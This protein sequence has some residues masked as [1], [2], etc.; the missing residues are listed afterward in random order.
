MSEELIKLFR[1]QL[2]KKQY[3]ELES[4]WLE[5]L[6]AG[7][8]L[9]EL[10]SLVELALRWA[11]PELPR[12]LLWVL[13]DALAEEKRYADELKV[14][15]RLVA[16]NPDDDRL[17]SALSRCLHH[18][19]PDE[20]LLERLLQKSGL[21]YGEPLA[22]A[23]NRF[24]R[25]LLMLPGQ[26]VY[27][28]QHGPGQV[29]NLDLLF[30]RITV[31][32]ENGI[33]LT[34]DIQTAANRFRF[35]GPDRFFYL[36]KNSPGRLTELASTD[37]TGLVALYLRDIGKPATA[38]EIQ[39]ALEPLVGTERYPA[40]W[41][42]AKKGLSAHPHIIVSARPPR[43]YRWQDQPVE[44]ERL[45][46]ARPATT[47]T[48]ELNP[49]SVVQQ[50]ADA[51]LATFRTLR[52]ATERKKLLD[53]IFQHRNADWPEIYTRMFLTGT[54]RRTGQLIRDRL[55]PEKW[56]ALL[57]QVLTDY[58][59]RPGAFLTVAEMPDA[60]SARQI[61]YRLL[62]LIET[63]PDRTRRNQARKILLAD[64]Y[65]LFAAALS[66]MDETD[67]RRLRDRIKASRNLEPF[68]QDEIVN[69][70]TS[71]FAGLSQPE[72]TD[73]IWTTGAGLERA[74]AELN[75]LTGVEL[76]RS[77]EEIARARA[78]GD[79]S[80]NYEYKAA[81]EKQARLMQ[82]INRLQTELS[83]ARVIEPDTID[84]GAVQVGCR[85]RLVADDGTTLEYA[86]LGPWDAD[87]EQG[88]ISFQ[89]PLAQK[90]LGKKTGDTVEI[91]NRSLKIATITRAL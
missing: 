39:A 25:Y 4:T 17:T 73:I 66:E 55:P 47:R 74:K 8:N 49:D 36:L 40:F 54:D 5:L 56:Q 58:R 23:L 15:R 61:V 84:T 18:L 85:V 51:L 9:D 89:S 27:D 20:P 68:Q 77:A 13:A 26:L 57:T 2:G 63:D 43:T 72:S 65:R 14:L 88:V 75:H 45:T 31:K 53:L 6:A 50:S 60:G 90:L 78:F 21:G 33:E 70:I 19:Y 86:I 3:S 29:N 62:D 83:R 87:H 34:V 82:K 1:T 22:Q 30:D 48:L 71:R 80:E 44:K 38:A 76:P 11:P 7:V 46:P 32:F 10:L 37:P 16:L 59:T 79:L 24:D 41:E 81:K 35:P 67:A 28:Q 42:K 91:E 12:T 64:N 69:L 52:T